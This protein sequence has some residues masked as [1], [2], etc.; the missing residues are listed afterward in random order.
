MSLDLQDPIARF[1]ELDKDGMIF[2]SAIYKVWPRAV[3]A[4]EMPLPSGY[5]L[6]ED[7][8]E[9]DRFGQ[10]NKDFQRK[11]VRTIRLLGVLQLIATV[12][13]IWLGLKFL[14]DSVIGDG[15]SSRVRFVVLFA[16]GSVL[17]SIFWLLAFAC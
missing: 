8:I 4:E 6:F 3:R 2:R 16:V 10:M 12:I 15:T 9:A 13:L 5:S 11:I 17:F 7:V 1:K 14:P